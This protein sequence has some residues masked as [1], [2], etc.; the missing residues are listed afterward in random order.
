VSFDD[1]D[2]WQSLRL[3]MPAVS[4]RDIKIKDDSTCL[5]SDLVAGTHGRGFW[6]LDNVTP[7]RQA[8]E[9]QAATGA[10]LFKPATAVRV[11]SGTNDPTEWTPELPHGENPMPGGI[12]DYWLAADAAGPV[13]LDIIDARGVA[14]RSLS[15]EDPVLTPDPALDPAGYDRICRATPTAPN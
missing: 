4:V 10:Y 9:V 8:A 2:H 14:V 12:I 3:N 7:L 1:G 15:S 6:I 5:C 11:R 13:T